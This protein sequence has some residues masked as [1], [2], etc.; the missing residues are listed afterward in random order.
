LLQGCGGGGGG[1]GNGG[2]QP[3]RTS[4]SL[5]ASVSGL[6]GSVTLAANSSPA[7]TISSNSQATLA[8]LPSGTAYSV[9]ITAQPTTHYCTLGASNGTLNA[10]ATIAV[11][12]VPRIAARKTTVAGLEVAHF[13]VTGLQLDASDYAGSIDGMAVKLAAVDGKLALLMPPLSDGAHRLSVSVDG[14]SYPID[15]NVSNPALPAAPAQMAAEFLSDVERGLDAMKADPALAGLSDWTELDAQL[16]AL[17][18]Q[19]PTLSAADLEA[20][21]RLFWSNEQAAAAQA[22][23][24]SFRAASFKPGDMYCS[25]IHS[26]VLSRFIDVVAYTANT[27]AI[28]AIGVEFGPYGAVAGVS[29]G[30]TLYVL[31]AWPAMKM[32]SAAI[33]EYRGRQCFTFIRLNLELGLEEAFRRKPAFGT[34]SMAAV[35]ETLTFNHKRTREYSVTGS[36]ELPEELRG[37]ASYAANIVRY[38]SAFLSDEAKEW[39]QDWTATYTRPIDL[40][41]FAL[42]NVSDPRIASSM[43]IGAEALRLRFEYLPEQMPQEPVDFTFQLAGNNQSWQIPARLNLIERPVAHAAAITTQTNEAY[44]GDLTADFAESFRISLAPVNGHVTLDATSG[45]YEYTPNDEYSGSDSFRFVAVNDRGESDPAEMQI[46][47][48]NLCD[49]SDTGTHIGLT[50]YRDA[51]KTRPEFSETISNGTHIVHTSYL[52]LVPDDV[53]STRMAGRYEFHLAGGAVS[54]IT[55]EKQPHNDLPQSANARVVYTAGSPST[56]AWSQTNRD[57]ENLTFNGS[58]IFCESGS[59]T[60]RVYSGT[61]DPV[62][63]THYDDTY[64]RHDVNVSGA[65]PITA[66]TALSILPLTLDDIRVWQLW[67]ASPR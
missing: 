67:N 1:G 12:C 13:D 15:F 40:A 39:L 51:A 42:S 32:L 55:L 10:D 21:V 36:G 49:H 52:E 62:N 37:S 4:Y 3:S 9:E 8:R 59:Y 48:T 24:P 53:N 20:L 43:T 18:A 38:L 7:V 16:A 61:I 44:Q 35:Q 64:T 60:W 28:M 2:E 47:V 54:Q 22:H 31:K 17:K 5:V 50:C 45:R 14:V 46:T 65:C 66:D 57:L 58:S 26:R 30:M 25:E 23:A 34:A 33:G 6:E 29:A 11:A 41:D 56:I 63:G 27:A 19:I